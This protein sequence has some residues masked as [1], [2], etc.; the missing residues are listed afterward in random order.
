[1]GLALGAGAARGMAHLGVL[2]VLVQA[3]VPIDM[4]AGSSIGSVFGA[5]YA[6]GA[7]LELLVGL[8]E[9]LSQ[10]HLIDLTV[11]R[12]GLIRGNKI[13]EMLRLL[14][15]GKTFDELSLPLYVVAVDIETGEKVIINKGS[16]AEAVRASIAIPG[17]FHPKRL[18]G[19]LLVD[20]AVLNSVPI[21]VARENGADFVIAVDVK[22]GGLAKRASI[23]NI[24][25]VI[26]HS[27][28]LLQLEVARVSS[29]ECDILIQ[30]NLAHINPA[31]FDQAVECIRLGEEAAHAALP[32]I[33]ELLSLANGR[34]CG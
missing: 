11:P 21:D 32:R 30:P 25:D 20:G 27:I 22:Y 10:K 34:D 16:V 3:G 33:K 9:R 15:K 23:N 28:D 6:V 29:A 12:L 14:T 17:I 31:R 7:D 1:M 8:A 24:F 5:L 18:D 26:L 4:I 19:R 2:R 13:E